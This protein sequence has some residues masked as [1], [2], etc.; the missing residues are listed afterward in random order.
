MRIFMHTELPLLKERRFAAAIGNDDAAISSG[1]SCTDAKLVGRGIA[2]PDNDVNK[3]NETS[4]KEKRGEWEFRSIP[5]NFE[6]TCPFGHGISNPTPYQARRPPLG[7]TRFT[8]KHNINVAAV[9]S[10]SEQGFLK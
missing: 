2:N 10:L 6:P 1:G 9:L 8:L 4:M 3:L 5:Q 7:N